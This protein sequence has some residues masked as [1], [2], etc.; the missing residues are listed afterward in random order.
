MRDLDVRPAAFV[1][2]LTLH[3]PIVLVSHS[4]IRSAETAVVSVWLDVAPDR[5][6]E[7]RE[8]EPPE[9]IVN[10]PRST[11]RA[12]RETRPATVPP[13]AV[14]EASIDWSLSG[15]I[16]AQ[17]AVEGI[18]RAEGYRALGPRDRQPAEPDAAPS[19]F[20]TPKHKLGDSELDPLNYDI[21]W[22]NDR[23]YTELGKPVTPRA[24][25]HFNLPKIPKCRL[26]GIGKKKARGDLFEHLKR[27]ED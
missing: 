1:I 22:H 14:S 5:P 6:I 27:D 12:G 10:E 25:A 13:N 26:I 4:R 23:C 20:T 9:P 24:D 7:R 8:N 18:A 16:A 2:V 21:V 3:A 17:S 15:A 19:I 11:A